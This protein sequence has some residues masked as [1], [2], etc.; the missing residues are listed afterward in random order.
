MLMELPGP[1]TDEQRMQLETVRSNGRHLLSI[2]NDILD[3]ARIESGKLELHFEPVDC[4]KL[5]D[6]VAVGLRSLAEEKDLRLD[7]DTPAAEVSL[8][9]DRRSLRQILINLANNAIKFTDEGWIRIGLDLMGDEGARITRFSVIDTGIGIT[10]EEQEKLFAAFEQ[11]NESPTRRRHEGTGLGLHIS[12]RLAA[13]IGA[14]LTF[15]SEPGAGA[16]F[17]LEVRE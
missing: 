7:V 16:T 10:P 9:T 6:E 1:L 14:T 8:R 2:I 5:V 17:T 3:L 11:L 13:A 15:D 4:N 12:Q